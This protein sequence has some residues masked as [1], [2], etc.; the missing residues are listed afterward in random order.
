MISSHHVAAHLA[1][2]TG[3]DSTLLRGRV[4]ILKWEKRPLVGKMVLDR[5]PQR[6]ED[7]ATKQ[8]LAFV[9]TVSLPRGGP[10]NEFLWLP[11]FLSFFSLRREDG[12]LATKNRKRERLGD[13]GQTFKKSMPHNLPPALSPYRPVSSALPSL[14]TSECSLF[15]A[16]SY[17]MALE[18]RECLS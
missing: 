12:D 8:T 9:K 14:T 1:E 10:R 2:F 6:G 13:E 5:V 15:G 17:H 3:K 7:R 16:L 11:S 4:Q 18:A